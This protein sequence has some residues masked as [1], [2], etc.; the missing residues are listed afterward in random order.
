MFN[1]PI[2]SFLSNENTNILATGRTFYPRLSESGT[3]KENI[4]S[5]NDLVIINELIMRNF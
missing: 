5:E 3:E 1:N 4:K 2:Q